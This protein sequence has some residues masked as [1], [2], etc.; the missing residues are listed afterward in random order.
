MPVSWCRDGRPDRRTKQDE[1]PDG[2]ADM[3]GH[4]GRCPLSGACAKA[5]ISPVTAGRWRETGLQEME[6]RDDD[7]D[8]P[9]TLHEQFVVMFEAARIE[10]QAPLVKQWR[11]VAIGDKDSSEASYR[12]ARDLLAATDPTRWSERVAAAGAGKL[13]L[14]GGLE[15]STFHHFERM[16][17][18]E[19]DHHIDQLDRQIRGGEW[20]VMT[21]DQQDSWIAFFEDKVERMRRHREGVE[22]W[23]GDLRY[24]IR[25]GHPVLRD[26]DNDRPM[27]IMPPRTIPIDL[28]TTTFPAA[29][30][31]AAPTGTSEPGLVHRG[32]DVPPLEQ[33]PAPAPASARVPA[34]F[35]YDAGSGLAIPMPS[36]ATGFNDEDVVL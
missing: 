34:G 4:R 17:Y 27:A 7:D 18:E 36:G 13:Q 11:K 9:M 5:G 2:Y 22:A 21:H 1:P 10:F 14:S 20:S 12:A 28:E 32:S 8:E 6:A 35:G 25:R 30:T 33:A 16:R 26:E 29:D 23:N 31:L 3:R 15:N 24:R 19:L